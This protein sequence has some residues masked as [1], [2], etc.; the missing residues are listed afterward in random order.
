MKM[1]T[2]FTTVSLLVL[3]ILYISFATYAQTSKKQN[4]TF[5][6]TVSM[7][8]PSTNTFHVDLLCG[9]LT[10][11]QN[12]FKIPV[13]M[14]G[15]YQIMNY[16]NDIQK[17]IIIDSN[18][19]PIKWEKAN[20]NTWRVYNKGNRTLKI[21][22][23]VKTVRSFVATN[24]LDEERGFIAPTGMFLHI[25]KQLNL[26]VTVKIN[27]YKNWNKIATGL[28]KI[29]GEKNTYYA[30]DFDILYDSPILIG[31]LEEMPSFTV[32]GIPHHFVGYKL[33]DFNRAEFM[34][35][36]KKVVEQAVA[37]IGDIPFDSY[38]FIGIGP[39]GGGIEHQNSTAVAFSG[40]KAFDTKQGR[41][42]ILSFLGHEYFHHYNAKRIR[43]IELGPFDYD[44]GS[45]TNMLW[46]AEGV[47]TYYDE[48]LLKWADLESE[49]DLLVGFQNSIKAYEN[50][51]GRFFQS[52]SQASYDT[53]SD[54][55][56]GRTG[57]EVNK[58]ISYYE[59]GPILAL[60]LDLKIRHE[61]KNQKSLDDV[62]RTLYYDFYKKLDRGYTEQEFRAVCEKIAN[63]QL[64]EFFNYV[65][66]VST[67]DYKKYFGYAG[68]DIDTNPKA[69]DGAWLGIKAILRDDKLVVRDVDWQSPAW[70]EGIRRNQIISKINGNNAT[71]E[72]LANIVQ[73]QKDGNI[74]KLE[75]LINDVVKTV[76]ILLKTKTEI[77]FDIKRKNTLTP[78]QQQILKTWLR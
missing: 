37:V 49:T 52:V 65:Y 40:S 24:Y 39:G 63:V 13:W 77:T 64:N 5:H 9:G 27:P 59:K 76:P 6:Y 54:G 29:D 35:E 15:Y 41:R 66:T 71:L 42:G 21:S 8:N 78:L 14:P 44:N 73:Q 67:P 4:P 62:M 7:E 53:W 22:Y 30:K 17:L 51:P 19:Q 43:P 25:D 74:V 23:D 47:T 55:P 10:E 70:V 56:F 3:G 45:K 36:L 28:T 18:N 75:V 1:R 20:H 32:K 46:V 2:R 60:M 61:T 38:T 69:T 34:S 50:S 58:T 26:P 11:E 57:D 48:M 33:G 16:A 31:L 68:L 12:D 72:L